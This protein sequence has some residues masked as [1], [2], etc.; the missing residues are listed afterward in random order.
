MNKT[1]K[2]RKL[3]TV[4]EFEKKFDEGDDISSNLDLSTIQVFEPGRERLNLEIK[5]VNLDIPQWMVEALDQA[6]ERIGV[7]RQNI[8][9][10]W[11]AER[12]EAQLR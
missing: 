12:L 6:A 11:I 2:M 7:T 9:K 4:A 3:P 8:I 10:M 1:S 5:K